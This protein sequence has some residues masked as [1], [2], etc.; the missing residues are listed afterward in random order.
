MSKLTQGSVAITKSPTLEKAKF[1]QAH[2]N[3]NIQP[4]HA[5]L[6]KF[7]ARAFEFFEQTAP[8]RREGVVPA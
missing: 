8:R 6:L 3:T 5:P 1:T 4:S 2:L 7:S